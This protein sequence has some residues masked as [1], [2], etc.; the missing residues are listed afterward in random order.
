MLDCHV[1]N[2]FFKLV[3]VQYSSNLLTL[4]WPLCKNILSVDYKPSITFRKCNQWKSLETM[5]VCLNNKNVI[6]LNTTT[7]LD[8]G[9]LVEGWASIACDPNVACSSLNSFLFQLLYWWNSAPV[10]KKIKKCWPNLFHVITKRDTHALLI[11]LSSIST[12]RCAN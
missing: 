2:F 7:M 9:G 11:R 10:N 1:I 5:H 6:I 4:T 8:S 12:N 3:T